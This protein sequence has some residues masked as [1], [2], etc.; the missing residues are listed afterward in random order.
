M[1][2]AIGSLVRIVNAPHRSELE[3]QN[4]YVVQIV[5]KA[6]GRR[7]RIYIISPVT[8]RTRLVG[9]MG[10]DLHGGD[11]ISAMGDLVRLVS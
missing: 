11:V 3:G 5:G 1:K 4:G 2:I 10:G 6:T 9:C 8:N 7:M